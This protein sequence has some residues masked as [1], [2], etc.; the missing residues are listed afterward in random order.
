MKSVL[1]GGAGF[2]GAHLS[3][4]L[5][6]RGREVIVYDRQRPPRERQWPGVAFVTGDLATALGRPGSV[7]DTQL[8]HA[9]AGA[10]VVHL[11]AWGYLP[12]T[13][14]QHMA[15][16]IR[17]NIEG[18]VALLA[19]CVQ[20]KVGRVIFYSS[21]GTIY[22]S[23]HILPIPE[24]H[25]AQ[26]YTAHAINKVAVEMYLSLFHRRHGLD[27]V[28]LRPGNPFGPFQNP[29]K[30]QGVIPAFL[31]RLRDGLPVEVWGDGEVVRDYFYVEDLA[32]AALLAEE[33]SHV[34]EIFNIACGEG[35]SL[36]QIIDALSAVVGGPIPVQWR[37]ARGTDVPV[38]ILDIAKARRLLGWEPTISFEE[39]LARTWREIRG[40]E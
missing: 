5:A 1:I 25:P 20:A 6:E 24:S 15:A 33:T 40:R 18:Y 36:N 31:Y 17:D 10:D 12:A 26:P 29:E 22:G 21:G 4:L 35:R 9:L 11:L 38:N 34:G 3:R 2:V 37:P 8:D 7:P 13:S 39:G 30:P 27:F 28:V 32:G 19:R 16:S 14:N 23:P